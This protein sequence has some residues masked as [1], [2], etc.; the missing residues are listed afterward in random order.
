M[1]TRPETPAYLQAKG[2]LP[3]DLHPMLEQMVR[4]YKFAALTHHRQQMASPKVIAEL[5]MMGWRCAPLDE[6]APKQHN[7]AG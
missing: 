5:I 2:M 4:E 1:T 3:S 6:A 7:P